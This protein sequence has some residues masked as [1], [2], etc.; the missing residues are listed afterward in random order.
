MDSTLVSFGGRSFTIFS[1]HC[2]DVMQCQIITLCAVMHSSSEPNP[3]SPAGSIEGVWA[4][5]RSSG[6]ET[7]DAVLPCRG[8]DAAGLSVEILDGGDA[9]GLGKGCEDVKEA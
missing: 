4:K 9:D 6:E 1:S 3:G 7:C 2:S 5:D 8:S